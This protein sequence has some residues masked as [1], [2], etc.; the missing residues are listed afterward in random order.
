M[1]NYLLM[2][3]TVL[4]LM[5]SGCG[6]V[7]IKADKEL[8]RQAKTFTPMEKLS[9][10]YFYMNRLPGAYFQ[11]ILNVDGQAVSEMGL[12]TFIRLELPPGRHTMFIKVTHVPNGEVRPSI[13]VETEA[14]RNY[15]IEQ[16]M[17]GIFEFSLPGLKQ[18]DEKTGKEIVERL[19]MVAVP[20]NVAQ[21]FA[22]KAAAAE[23]KRQ[24]EAI[25]RNFAS[26]DKIAAPQ[27]IAG[28]GGKYM[29][30]FT[31]TGAVALWA[32]KPVTGTDNGSELAAS[33]GGA[34]G[35][36]V[37][38]KVFENIPFVGGMIGKS[39]G[40]E[41]ARAATRKKIEP[42]L[43]SLD[44]VRASSDISFNTADELA[45][46][47]YA[48][49]STHG[50]YARVLALTQKI[51]PELQ[52][53]YTTAVAKASQAPEPKKE[54]MQEASPKERLKALQKLKK[55]GLISEA[56]FRAKKN[57]ILKSL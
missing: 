6:G 25:Q 56:D 38:N 11:A 1:R 35:Q 54:A 50:Q 24:E 49:H 48:K 29:S 33:V 41:A 12:G 13:E 31:A 20:E 30:P 16:P 17:P 53:V 34:V 23:R 14:G 27:P 18:V 32:Q 15:F 19:S 42:E 36:Q 47:M 52:D 39:V 22:A 4:A 26:P 37:A 7:I 28:N 57:E 45:V 51:Y 55:E 2:L 5:L 43:P 44:A 21:S 46:Y 3:T 8:E 40:E 10:V 9:N